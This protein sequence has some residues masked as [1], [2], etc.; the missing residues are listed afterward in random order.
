MRLLLR[1][2]WGINGITIFFSQP[3][4]PPPTCPWLL[5]QKNPSWVCDFW[6]HW[7]SSLKTPPGLQSGEEG[8]LLCSLGG[9]GYI[10]HLQKCM[11]TVQNHP[12]LS[13]NCL[14]P[15]FST[16]YLPSCYVAHLCSTL[17]RHQNGFKL[18]FWPSKPISDMGTL[19]LWGLLRYN[20][21]GPSPL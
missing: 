14:A 20:H 9:G 19:L 7:R 12:L 5:S 10:S 3:S 17:R 21:I 4:L 15:H 1:Y 13:E 8:V 6:S 18:N 11:E 2:I 16:P